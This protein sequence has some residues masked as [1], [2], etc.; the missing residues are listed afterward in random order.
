[1]QAWKVHSDPESLPNPSSL[2]VDFV[3]TGRPALLQR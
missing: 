1:M 2:I 3:D